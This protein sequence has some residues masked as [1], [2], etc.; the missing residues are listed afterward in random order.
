MCDFIFASS[1]E[2]SFYYRVSKSNLQLLFQPKQWNQTVL[3]I[4]L[5]KCSLDIFICV[6]FQIYFSGKLQLY[7]QPFSA[8]L[9]HG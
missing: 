1:L 3:M 2:F 8:H 7:L 9:K 6:I 4:I 5:N